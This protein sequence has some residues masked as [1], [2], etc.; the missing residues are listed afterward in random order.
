MLIKRNWLLIG[1][2]IVLLSAFLML[3]SCAKEEETSPEEETRRLIISSSLE[4][5]EV[6]EQIYNYD[7]RTHRTSSPLI[8]DIT[9]ARA[10]WE[11]NI[12]SSSGPGQ[13]FVKGKQF[14]FKGEAYLKKDGTPIT[15][16]LFKSVLSIAVLKY[17][18][19]EFAAEDY[20]NISSENRLKALTFEDIV[21]RGK[22]E[23]LPEEWQ[24]IVADLDHQHYLLQSGQFVI[25]LKGAEEASKDTMERI[26]DQYGGKG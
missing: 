5:I 1:L 15:H 3:F 4:P 13:G 8:Y 9:G 11:A 12:G 26:I 7:H 19:P 21:L 22:L 6:L 20:I 16:D 17:R 14:V 24:L 25:Y 10:E 23:E 2:V 18:S